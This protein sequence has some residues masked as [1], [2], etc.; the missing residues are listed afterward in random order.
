MPTALQDLRDAVDRAAASLGAEPKAPPTFER[1][2]QADH[3]DYATNAALMLAGALKA[4]PRDVAERLASAVQGELGAALERVDVAGPG[5]LNLVL[6]DGWYATALA[7]VLEAGE[8]FGAGT[9]ARR[10]RV[11]VEFV[12]ANPT[13]PL[14]VGHARNAAFGDAV[15]RLLAH[16][17]HDVVREFYVNDFGTQVLRLGDLLPPRGSRTRRP[18]PSRR[19]PARPSR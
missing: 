10:L 18:P 15:A 6:T 14:H 19:S 9:A 2:R 16:A 17:G 8:A 5:F 4:K 12:S 11:N 7:G 13:G 3:G 1:P